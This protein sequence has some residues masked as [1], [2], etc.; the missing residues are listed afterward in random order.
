MNWNRL[1]WGIEYVSTKSKP[2]LIGAFWDDRVFGR[3]D[4]YD[5]E[6]T[7]A[8]LFCTRQSARDWCKISNKAHPSQFRIVR[9]R[10]TV[11]RP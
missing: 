3:G 5:G 1:L 8:L 11:R 9:V 10:E 6:P 7:R 2:V 4:F